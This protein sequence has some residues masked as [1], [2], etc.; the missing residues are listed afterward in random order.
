MLSL[1]DPKMFLLGMWLKVAIYQ[2]NGTTWE[3]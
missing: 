3:A 2:T 1:H